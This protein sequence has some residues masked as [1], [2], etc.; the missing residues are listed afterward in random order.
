MGGLKQNRHPNS[1][2]TSHYMTRSASS[3]FYT[4]YSTARVKHGALKSKVS[5]VTTPQLV[6]G[7]APLTLSHDESDSRV[8]GE[9]GLVA[10]Q[11]ITVHVEVKRALRLVEV[12]VFREGIPE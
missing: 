1:T 7:T 11:P 2:T 10:I 5:L 8:L 6:T 9:D 3:S 12:W 4:L